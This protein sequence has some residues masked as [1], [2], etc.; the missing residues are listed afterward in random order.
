M[1]K[2]TIAL[3]A[4]MFTAA[5]HGQKTVQPAPAPVTQSNM[6]AAAAGTAAPAAAA[7]AVKAEERYSCPMHADVTAKEPGK[8]SKCGMALV[9]APSAPTTPAH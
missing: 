8:C 2:L 3:S 9:A 4:L 5:C 1:Q 6:P 7:P